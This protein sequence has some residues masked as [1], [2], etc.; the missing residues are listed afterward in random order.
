MK[1]DYNRKTI[2]LLRRAGW[3]AA[4]VQSYNAR[5]NLAHDLFGV[6][7]VLAYIPE[8]DRPGALLVQACT[9]GD[10]A[11]RLRKVL[12]SDKAWN[13][14]RLGFRA[15]WVMHWS[16]EERGT[17]I[18]HTPRIDNIQ[19]E[20]FERYRATGEIPK[21]CQKELSE[22]VGSPD[23]QSEQRTGTDTASSTPRLLLVKGSLITNAKH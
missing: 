3:E 19:H 18:K 8:I 9:T 10:R 1:T 23:V 14:I 4:L 15:F 12:E 21:I 7:D 13:W 22:D 5:Y 17:T 20:D 11:K 6:A 2:E 16:K